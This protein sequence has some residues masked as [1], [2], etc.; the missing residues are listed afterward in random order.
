M[1]TTAVPSI[2]PILLALLLG[3]LA[4]A[5]PAE[6]QNISE[7]QVTPETVTLRVGQKQALFSTAFDANGNVIATAHFTYSSSDSGVAQVQPDGVVI[8]RRPGSATVKVSSG[9]RSVTVAVTVGAPAGVP[10]PPDTTQAPAAGPAA[11]PAVVLNI[12]PTPIYLLPSEN[13]RLILHGFAQDGSPTT[14]TGVTWKS[15]TP[16]IATVDNEGLV[17]GITPGQG[18]VQASIPGGVVATAPVEVATAEFEIRPLGQLIMAPFDID[19]FTAVVPSQ[20][21]REL[22][23]GVQWKV[24]VPEVIRVGPTGIVQGLAPGQAEVIAS[25]FLQEKRAPVLVHRPVQ[26]VVYSPPSSRGPVRMPLFGV[27]RFTARALAADSTPV[28]EAVLTWTVQDTA[29]ATFDADSGDLTARGVGTTTLTLGT[30]EVDPITWVIEVVP[31]EVALDRGRLALLPGERTTLVA[32]LID[33]NGARI[34]PASDL[35]WSSDNGASAVVGNDGVVEAT[36]FG[37]ARVTARTRWGKTA[38]A[39]VYT[40]GDLVFSSNRSGGRFGIYQLA[41]RDPLRVAAIVTDSS[42]SGTPAISPDRTRIAFTSDHTGDLELYVMDADGGNPRQLTRSPGAD[43]DPAWTPDGSH[44]VFSSARS[45]ALQLYSMNADGSGLQQLTSV[46][47]NS[48]P[49]V[50]PDGRTI[51]FVSTRDGNDEVYRM[52]I[53]GSGQVNV[54]GSKDREDSPHYFPNGDLAIAA[55]VRRR[56]YQVLRIPADGS[57]PVTVTSNPNPITSFGVSRDGTLLAVVAGRVTDPRRGRAQFTFSL[58][59]ATPGNV[60]VTIPLVL[61]EQIGGVGF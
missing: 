1:T 43:T 56:G 18:I 41:T 15:L 24:S 60:V 12:T 13:L 55:E 37:H 11:A 6:A 45:G 42:Q 61:N 17:V 9:Q 51:A 28:P 47:V 3:P 16:S 46:G 59:P 32:S 54:T 22:H 8:G 39:D 34:G 4:A 19:T 49:V 21:D 27:R 35:E 20:G 25:G 10:Q 5:T 58:E 52:A 26:T 33:D 40:V 7:V 30:R 57:A 36:G 31:G 23:S 38:S 53:D 2:R 44:L 14:V 48:E 50:S 29:V